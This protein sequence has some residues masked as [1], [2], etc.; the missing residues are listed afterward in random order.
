MSKA[1]YMRYQIETVQSGE[2]WTAH[3]YPPSTQS[4]L[5]GP[6][7]ATLSEG[8]QVLLGRAYDA[9]D[10]DLANQKQIVNDG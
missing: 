4:E 3:I 9:V 1:T 8:E 10:K 7:T 6:F 2:T 5:S